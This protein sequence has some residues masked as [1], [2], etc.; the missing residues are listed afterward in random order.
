MQSSLHSKKKKEKKKI[1]QMNLY[2][3]LA[4][5]KALPFQM[6]STFRPLCFL[7][8]AMP[9]TVLH[10]FRATKHMLATDNSGSNASCF[11]RLRHASP[12]L[13]AQSNTY[14]GAMFT[15]PDVTTTARTKPV[16]SAGCVPRC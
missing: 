9:F 15:L 14:V 1:L 7:T 8:Q 4:N 13:Y 2:K 11:P 10:A 16:Y 3:A 5:H 12:A 6:V